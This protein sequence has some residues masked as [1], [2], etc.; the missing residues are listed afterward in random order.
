MFRHVNQCDS[1]SDFMS[2][3]FKLLQVNGDYLWLWLV[4]HGGLW[5]LKVPALGLILHLCNF[6]HFGANQWIDQ[7]VTMLKK[8][9][10]FQQKL[11]SR[12]VKS[13]ATVREDLSPPS[14]KHLYC[15][16]SVEAERVI[17][18]P[19]G[20]GLGPGNFDIKQTLVQ[21]CL[22]VNFRLKGEECPGSC[23]LRQCAP[24]LLSSALLRSSLLVSL[25]L[26]T[27]TVFTRFYNNYNLVQAKCSTGCDWSAQ[28]GAGNTTWLGFRVQRPRIGWDTVTP[29]RRRRNGSQVE[30]VDE[31]M[32][33]L[34]R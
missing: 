1:I 28:A 14:F 13:T 11:V 17:V 32:S 27:H 25:L 15:A 19:N 18:H 2:R 5:S 16:A 23:G 12:T 31:Q 3:S 20:I 22:S 10:L 26:H 8:S 29:R 34:S 4:G 6:R 9:P 24:P 21:S 33:Q 30:P 7:S